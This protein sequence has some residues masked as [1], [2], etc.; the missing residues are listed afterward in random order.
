M[1]SQYSLAEWRRW[2]FI[3]A[4]AMGIMASPETL[5]LSANGMG[6]IGWLY[7]A[8][9]LVF[10]GVYLLFAGRY[11]SFYSSA[12]AE[13][14]G[15]V[16]TFPRHVIFVLTIYGRCFFAVT[17]GTMVLA[18][19]GYVFNEHFVLW[20]PNLAF[21][22]ALLGVLCLVNIIS[23]RISMYLQAIFLTVFVVGLV[24]LIAAGFTNPAGW[25]VPQETVAST[26]LT[27]WRPFLMAV[28]LFLGFEAAYMRMENGE[29]AETG[30]GV[31]LTIILFMLILGLW[32]TVSY[33]YVPAGR[34][35]ITTVPYATA[36]RAIMGDTGAKV[37]SLVI[38]AGSI[39]A[40]NALLIVSASVLQ[41]WSHFHMLPRFL[42]F[43]ENRPVFP[44]LITTAAIAGMMAAGQAGYDE[45]VSRMWSAAYIWLA[46]YAMSLW[47][48]G[49]L[50]PDNKE[51]GGKL[52]GLRRFMGPV[53][54]L[55]AIL[56]ILTD[57]N[58][59]DY[60]WFMSISLVVLFFISVS[61]SYISG[62]RP[63]VESGA[64]PDKH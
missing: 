38:L 37:I 14:S 57:K 40:V 43:P 35:A 20:F 23:P 30:K 49:R 39:M 56:L 11:N 54:G 60:V 22:F 52:K 61:W 34:L 55:V 44:M 18:R 12:G 53:V 6:R 48:E 29:V 46:V 7:F 64:T 33:L 58:W 13:I 36:A 27:G 10:A 62:R 51:S 21:S 32:L 25:S 2:I 26:G 19:A 28:F 9:V 24:V 45:T 42:N 15:L 1:P 17:A 41:Q 31:Y 3:I 16:E 8:A 5:V 63:D 47:A 50:I 4:L 59:K